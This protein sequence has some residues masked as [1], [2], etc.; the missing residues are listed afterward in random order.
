MVWEKEKP[1]KRFT[2]QK[3]ESLGRDRPTAPKQMARPTRTGE[4]P[5]AEMEGATMAEVVTR[6]TV[7]EPWAARRI[8]LRIKASRIRGTLKFCMVE[9]M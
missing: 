5:M 6:A 1:E 2:T 8:W 7:A 4:T 9:T 3:P